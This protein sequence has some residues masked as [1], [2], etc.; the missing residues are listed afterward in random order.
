M[1]KK[2]TTTA[3]SMSSELPAIH[4]TAERIN[5]ELLAL[6]ITKKQSETQEMIQT[7]D[8]LKKFG[9]V[10]TPRKSGGFFL[11]SPDLVPLRAFVTNIEDRHIIK[12]N[13]VKRE[14]QSAKVHQLSVAVSD[15]VRV[16]KS[17]MEKLLREQI[18]KERRL[19]T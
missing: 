3:S 17:M 11:E 13:A 16:R 7:I 5:D 8:E 9:W 6:R 15:M 18:Q 10:S 14:E 19:T 2:R 1:S 12:R 4:W